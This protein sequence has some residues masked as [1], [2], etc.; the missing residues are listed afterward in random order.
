V[1]PQ[2]EALLRS[3]AAAVAADDLGSAIAR[4][5]EF[6]ALVPQRRICATTSAPC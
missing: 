5:E 1:T 3:A 6:V 2:A 4:Y